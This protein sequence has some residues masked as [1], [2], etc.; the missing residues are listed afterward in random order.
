MCQDTAELHIRTTVYLGSVH[1]HAEAPGP[2][3]LLSKA[4]ISGCL[5][6]DIRQRPPGTELSDN[7]DWGKAEPHEHDQ[8][9]VPYSSHDGH[10]HAL[11]QSV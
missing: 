4:C 2:V 10:L 7:A 9:G 3:H 6:N 11:T 1:G 5:P 8:I